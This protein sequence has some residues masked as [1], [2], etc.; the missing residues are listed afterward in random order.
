MCVPRRVTCLL[1]VLNAVTA[2]RL[3][4]VWTKSQTV[5]FW[6]IPTG[7]S[8]IIFPTRFTAPSSG[9]SLS[10]P[11]GRTIPCQGE[12]GHTLSFCGHHFSGT[13]LLADF[14]FP[15]LNVDY[16]HHHHLPLDPATNQLVSSS[17]LHLP[18]S[19]ST[20]AVQQSSAAGSSSTGVGLQ[21]SSSPSLS[22]FNEPTGSLV[23]ALHLHCRAWQLL[24]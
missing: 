19:S 12:M 22:D 23:A 4:H 2:G 1:R 13:V 18:S 15:I 10:D 16:L 14:Q 21:L 17:A 7:A 3:A 24:M 5:V 11:S 20:T 9:P 8:Y 6:L